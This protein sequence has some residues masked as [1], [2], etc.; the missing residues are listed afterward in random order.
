[1]MT[2]PQPAVMAICAA[3]ATLCASGKNTVWVT[4]QVTTAGGGP[5]R[6]AVAVPSAEAIDEGGVVD[7]TGGATVTVEKVCTPVEVSFHENVTSS[8]LRCT[9]TPA[10]T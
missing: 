7:R 10:G 3:S 5:R 4:V 6:T 1:M 9:A 8:S 2:P